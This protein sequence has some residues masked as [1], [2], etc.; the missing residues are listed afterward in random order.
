[1]EDADLLLRWRNDPTTR[2]NSFDSSPIDREDHIRWLTAMLGNPRSARIWI[3][4]DGERAVG[5]V[6][7]DRRDRN[8]GE[9]SVAIDPDE[10]GRGFGVAII[11]LGTVRAHEELGVASVVAVVKAT[12]YASLAAFRRAGYAFEQNGRRGDE[13]VVTL[14]WTAAEHGTAR[15]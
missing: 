5:Q 7:V 15:R 9:I 11:Q 8:T 10:R 2:A 13:H 3:A 4:A 14:E 12:N 6:R 1:M